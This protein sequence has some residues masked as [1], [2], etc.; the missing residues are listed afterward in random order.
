[1]ASLFAH[2]SGVLQEKGYRKHC[3][4]LEALSKMVEK[5]STL[6]DSKVRFYK[7]FGLFLLL[8]IGVLGV[9]LPFLVSLD[10][11]SAWKENAVQIIS[12]VLAVSTIFNSMFKPTE[13]FSAACR[14][15]VR[16]EHFKAEVLLALE[17]LSKIDLDDTTLHELVDHKLKEFEKYQEELIG[18]FLPERAVTSPSAELTPSSG[19]PDNTQA[20]KPA[21]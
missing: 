9:I 5:N 16:I 18:L 10:G 1:M 6:T 2:A 4:P 7:W 20:V 8:L 3:Y 12:I 13:R 21:I 17:R 19:A 14:I 15:A 11:N